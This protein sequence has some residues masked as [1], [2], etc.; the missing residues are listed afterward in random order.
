MLRNFAMNVRIADRKANRHS[1]G[2]REFCLQICVS[3]DCRS[4]ALLPRMRAGA[5]NPT[6]A[7]FFVLLR[8]LRGNGF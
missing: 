8:V 4:C 1:I 5:Y 7:I 2:K 6:S 3:A